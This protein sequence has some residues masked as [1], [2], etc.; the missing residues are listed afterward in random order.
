MPEPNVPIPDPTTLTTE[1]LLR[2]LAAE[3]EYVNGQLGIRDQ[4]I[5]GM[6]RATKL[7]D[8]TVNRTPTLIQTEIQHV[9]EVMDERRDATNAEFAAAEK[10]VETAMASAEKAVA[11]AETANEKRFES[12]GARIDG[13]SEQMRDAMSRNEAD[14][15]ISGI[16]DKVNEEAK[17]TTERVNELDR[18]L[19]SRLDLMQGKDQGGQETK[20]G[21]YALLGAVAAVAVTLGALAAAG[22]FGGN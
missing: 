12:T 11:K 5:D 16:S 7:L 3:R 17:R 8:E 6:D 9:R 15:R 2:A 4:R 1:Q 22:V 10:A 19:S 14:V 13:L 18:R 20:A 21:L